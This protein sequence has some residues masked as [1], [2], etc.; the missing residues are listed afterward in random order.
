M[1]DPFKARNV[2]D[3]SEMTYR[4]PYLN[5]ENIGQAERKELVLVLSRKGHEVLE[6][7]NILY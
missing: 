1:R 6:N 7:H 2:G 3:S 4:N 5:R